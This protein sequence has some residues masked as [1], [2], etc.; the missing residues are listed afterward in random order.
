MN[1]LL[2]GLN[3]GSQRFL[4]REIKDVYAIILTKIGEYVDLITKTFTTKLKPQILRIGL[5]L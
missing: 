4:V 5:N 1:S 3:L 2:Q